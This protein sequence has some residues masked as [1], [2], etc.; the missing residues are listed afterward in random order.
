LE[1][2]LAA[3]FPRQFAIGER[4]GSDLALGDALLDLYVER[5]WIL[6]QRRSRVVSVT[7]KGEEKFRSLF[8]V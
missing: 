6:R 5:G 8:G 1:Y 3:F 4:Q 2:A 7:P